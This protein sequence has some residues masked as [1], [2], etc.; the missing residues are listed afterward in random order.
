MRHTNDVIAAYTLSFSD[1]P[2]TLE[3]PCMGGVLADEMGLGKTLEVIALLLLR[4]WSDWPRLG[5]QIRRIG[6]GPVVEIIERASPSDAAPQ[7]LLCSCGGV[8]ETRDLDRVQCAQCFGPQQHASCVQYEPD[9]FLQLLPNRHPYICPSCWS[10]VS[11][12]FLLT[13]DLL[14]SFNQ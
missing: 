6:G 11:I 9:K 14:I 10:N 5:G 3:S 1:R 2:P 4:A 13:S 7:M 12:H 8:E